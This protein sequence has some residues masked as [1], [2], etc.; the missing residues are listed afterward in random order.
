MV[1]YNRLK[2]AVQRRDFRGVGEE[3]FK[4]VDAAKVTKLPVERHAEKMLRHQEFTVRVFKRRKQ[5][6]QQALVPVQIQAPD[7]DNGDVFGTPDQQPK[8]RYPSKSRKLI[9]LIWQ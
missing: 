2:P 9:D 7:A 4:E 8:R 1:H 6:A 5:P 3:L